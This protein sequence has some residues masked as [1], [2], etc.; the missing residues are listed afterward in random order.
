MAI[1][2]YTR[3]ADMNIVEDAGYD[4]SQYLPTTCKVEYAFAKKDKG[5]WKV[6]MKTDI[7]ILQ[8]Y[9]FPKGGK[10]AWHDFKEAVKNKTCVFYVTKRLKDQTKWVRF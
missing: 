4:Y 3:E 2:D 6:I 9:H 7:G 1:L 10:Q 5:A 8:T